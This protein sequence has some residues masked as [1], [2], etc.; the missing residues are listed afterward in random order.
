VALLKREPLA[1]GPGDF[2]ASFKKWKCALLE[3]GGIFPDT[4]RSGTERA[5]EVLVTDRRSCPALRTSVLGGLCP[6]CVSRRAL[7]FSRGVPIAGSPVA[8]LAADV[9]NALFPFGDLLGDW[10][11]FKGRKYTVVGVLEAK[12]SLSGQSQDDFIAVPI[13]KVINLYGWERSLSIQV[14]AP[15]QESY[16][17]VQ[18]QA[19]SILREPPT[20][21]RSSPTSP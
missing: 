17:S 14:Q 20:T 15:N 9:R 3:V 16:D 6:A 4:I 5:L 12:S 7:R 1:P 18:E 8:V 19:R 13:T 2:P 10:V 11:Q 21:L